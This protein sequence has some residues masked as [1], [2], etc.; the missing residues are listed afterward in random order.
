MDSN[1]RNA[2]EQGVQVALAAT[3]HATPQGQLVLPIMSQS[4]ATAELIGSLSYGSAK[5]KR[6]SAGAPVPR[7]TPEEEE[8]LKMLVHELGEK[9]WQH[10]A[11]RLGTNRSGT[12]IE[13]HWWALMIFI[14]F[15]PIRALLATCRIYF[16][17][18]S[19]L[20]I[21]RSCAANANG[22]QGKMTLGFPRW[23][24]QS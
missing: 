11:D 22:L 5:K 3:V 1:L 16:H 8:R 10:I 24:H 15:C 20:T 17:R 2:H 13:Q 6:T 9:S 7:W 23:L 14:I 4:M 19:L 18:F 12:G 21:G